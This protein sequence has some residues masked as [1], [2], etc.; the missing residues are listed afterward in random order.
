MLEQ[1]NERVRAMGRA[2]FTHRDAEGRVISEWEQHNLIINNGLDGYLKA[3]LKGATT[4]G[5]SSWHVAL[6]AGKSSTLTLNSTDTATNTAYS[7]STGY[8]NAA[9][10]AWNSGAVSG[11]S[12]SS[13]ASKATFNID[14][15]TTAAGISLVSSS[16]KG[17]LG[18]TNETGFMH[19]ELAFS[20]T[21]SMSSGDTLD[22][23][24]SLS[25]AFS[26]S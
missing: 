20:N 23:G 18:T 16:V 2:V 21:R 15:G 26:S 9:R 8:S 3:R 11:Q 12:V 5:S 1:A 22:V 13:T 19:S 17:N 4:A 25:M 6:I 7:E 14:T 10:P 24:Y